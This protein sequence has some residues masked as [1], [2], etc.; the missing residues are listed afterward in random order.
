[1]P[2]SPSRPLERA[3]ALGAVVVACARLPWQI[4]EGGQA[5]LALG[6]ELAFALAA[7][8]VAVLAGRSTFARDRVA[9]LVLALVVV[10]L[11]SALFAQNRWLALRSFTLTLGGATVFLAARGARLRW[12]LLAAPGVVAASVLLEAHGVLHGLSRTGH[13]PGGLVGERNAAAELLVLA[14][15]LC[16]WI[17]VKTEQRGVR[18]LAATVAGAA[19]AAIVLA[20]TRS[21]WLA[22]GALAALG[23]VLALRADDGARA[24]A[25]PVAL[26]AVAGLGLALVL[27]N[28]LAW[29]DLHPYRA[30]WTHLVDASSP[31]GHGRLVQYANTWRMALSHPLLGVGPGNW[32][33]RYL[34]FTTPADPSLHGGLVPTNRL[35][36]SDLLGYLS[37]RGFVGFALVALWTW[38]LVRAR[39]EARW[40][41][42]ATLGALAIVGALD[43]VLQCAPHLFFVA[44]VLGAATPVRAARPSRSPRLAA[45]ALGVL[46][47]PA[48]MRAVALAY[49]VRAQGFADYERAL[50][51]DPGD[52]PRR[53]Q[54]ASD[55]VAAGRCEDAKRE[56]AGA[57]ALAVLGEE[58]RAV[59]RSCD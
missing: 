50:T 36:Q 12:E 54:I 45:A 51:L 40:L 55:E 58:A 46:V 22:L 48:A 24:R 18:A 26:A 10:D 4:A 56:L 1:M 30:T 29:T 27:P 49:F 14:L 7:F 13:A 5:H 28:A 37:E 41:R 11:A 19:T 39:D 15:P 33:S 32:A 53:V 35:P 47:I 38:D 2:L 20:R 44:A 42:R 9:G 3:L 52:V 43:A 34:E 16:A 31:S 57:A 21:A 17:A 8:V 59:V 23:L 25:T 6:Q